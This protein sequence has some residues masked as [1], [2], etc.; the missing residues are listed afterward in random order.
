MIAVL[1]ELR[2]TLRLARTAAGAAGDPTAFVADRGNLPGP[3]DKLTVLGAWIGPD[4]RVPYLYIRPTHIA[5]VGAACLAAVAVVVALRRVRLALPAV[6]AIVGAGA[7]YVSSNSGIYY[8]AKTY[9]VAAFP[10]ACAVVSGAA[11]LT[12][13]PW[14][15]RLAVPVAV[16][17]AL[18][19]GGVAAAMELGIGMAAR[20]AAVTPPEFRQ[21]QALGRRT[22]HTLGLALI[23]D[24]WAK[25]LLPDAAVPYDG[26]FGTHVRP[27]HS[28][29]GVLDIGSIDPAALVAVDWIAEPR[30]GGMST[31]P[32]P[33]RLRRLAAA[34]RLW[35]RA[36]GLPPVT[37]TLPLEPENAIGA[38]S[39]AP[40]AALVAPASGLL[41]GRAADGTLSFPVRWHLTGTAWGPWV[42]DTEFVVPSPVGGP[43]AGSA[44]E[45]GLGGSYRVA[46]IGQPT[47]G[48]RIQVD[49]RDLPPPD[50]SAA[51]IRRYQPLGVIRLAPGR[52]VLSLVAGGGGQIAYLLAISVEHVGRS[53]AVTICIAGR[54]E[55]LAPG[56]SV[57]VRR[58][59]RIT[60][61][62]G[63]AALLDRIDS[64]P[65]A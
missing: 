64:P 29:A 55:P 4:Y 49:G 19:L 52:H 65:A 33:F 1:P 39:L 26:S 35:A 32:A 25:T 37:A 2:R 23:E 58:G 43:P 18:A 62:G 51:G 20:A 46:L 8:T 53:A 12:R 7:L 34:Y 31:P 42:A 41:V 28:F 40:G 14:R 11:A 44:F 59:Q 3:V 38:L 36:P 21:L 5:M 30:L 9:Q 16:T 13:C 48:V 27:G 17:G 54:R 24:A 63:R 47:S 56:G 60:A 45:L 50:A 61:C 10:I 6:L 57:T 22:P 15:P